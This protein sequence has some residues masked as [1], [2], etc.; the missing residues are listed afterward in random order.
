M[1][2]QG[3]LEFVAAKILDLH[4]TSAVRVAVDGVDGAGK[5]TFADEMA[6]I[7]SPFGRQVIRASVDSFHNPRAVRY[8]LGRSSPLGFFSDSYDYGKLASLLLNPLGPGGNLRYRRAAFDVR[9]DSIFTAPEEQ[10][11]PDSILIFDGIFLHRPAL[12]PYWDFSI[13]LEVDVT[14]SIPRGAARGEGSPDPC[15]ESN[16]RYVEGQKIYL[17]ECEPARAAT[18]VIDNNDLERPFIVPFSR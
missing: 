17:S 16:R 3:L 15:A 14:I 13:F 10:A 4:S 8:R 18:V 2:R 6:S 7:L 9:T 11:E 12:R 1:P 5:T